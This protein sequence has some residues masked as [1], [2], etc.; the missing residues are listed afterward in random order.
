M[1]TLVQVDGQNLFH[2][3]KY[4]WGPASPYDYASYDVLKLAEALVL[5]TPGR[6]LEEVRFYTG[7]PDKKDRPT[8]HTFWKNKIRHLESQGI[9]VYEGRINAGGQEKGV[10]VALALDLVQATYDQR[11]DV[12][13]VVSQD[14]DF[15]PAVRLARRIAGNQG[16]TL[17]FESAFPF[18]QGRRISRRG[19]PETKWIRLDKPTYDAC[20]DPVDYR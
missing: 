9:T 15:T 2:L 5:L 3:A 4:A 18:E 6:T 7:V 1:C 16:V 20:L 8:L 10:D 11:Y 19:I 14:S 12:A 17:Q 13:I